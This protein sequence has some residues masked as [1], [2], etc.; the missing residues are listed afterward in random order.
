M[1]NKR[2]NYEIL[3]GILDGTAGGVRDQG[4]GQWQPIEGHPDGGIWIESAEQVD[5]L[6]QQLTDIE[7]SLFR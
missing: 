5:Q 2:S 6:N 7:K 4:R 3:D 1:G